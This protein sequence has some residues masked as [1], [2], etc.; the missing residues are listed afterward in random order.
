LA[1]PLVDGD[2]TNL[3][4]LPTAGGPMRAV[5]D[6]GSRAVLIVRHVDWSSDGRSLYA[7]IAD[8]DADVVM[9]DGLLPSE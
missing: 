8:V 9:L 3:W 2:T 6:F 7:A 1:L 4:L 5:T